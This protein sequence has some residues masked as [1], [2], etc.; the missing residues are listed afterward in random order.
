MSL[1]YPTTP[2]PSPFPLKG[3]GV[4]WSEFPRLWCRKSKIVFTNLPRSKYSSKLQ[5]NGLKTRR[6]HIMT[7]TRHILFI[8]FALLF[9]LQTWGQDPA[10]AKIDST[11]KKGSFLKDLIKIDAPNEF[12]KTKEKTASPQETTPTAQSSDDTTFTTKAKPKVDSSGKKGFFQ[13]LIKLDVK[14]DLLNPNAKL[15]DIKKTIKDKVA[16]NLKEANRI[17]DELSSNGLDLGL[18]EKK[19]G[20]KGKS[21]QKKAPKD[22][23]VGIKMVASAGNFG[24]GASATVEEF[25]VVKDDELEASI[26]AP[27]VRWYDYK[28]RRT[29]TTAIKDKSYSQILHGPYKRYV[30]DDLVEEGFFYMGTKDGRWE[31]YGKE[32]DQDIILLEKQYFWRG[33]PLESK[34]SFYD[35]EQTK[36]KEVIP[37]VNG[38]ATG[39]YYSF[40]D[41]GQ[42]MMEGRMDDSVKVGVWREYYQFG[43]GG[44]T[45]KVTQHGKDKYDTEFEPFIAEEYDQKGKQ[46]YKK[47]AE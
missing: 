33:F 12:I 38:K 19:I 26:Y 29:V 6:T 28:L 22:E 3:K 8:S 5:F 20:G 47:K 13:D 41:G 43:T 42:K 23:Y 30:G 9:S 44:R 34:I 18:R 10:K 46:T 36:I 14:S 39:T 27:E 32:A 21:S 37:M 1:P 2:I 45:K 16:K 25:N 4:T 40:Y 24:N 31:R 17:Q 11:K 15:K 35:K 7:N